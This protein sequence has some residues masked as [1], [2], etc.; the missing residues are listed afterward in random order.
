MDQ[1]E[2]AVKA[3]AQKVEQI[4]VLVQECKK[5]SVEFGIPFTLRDIE[6]YTDDEL[7]DEAYERGWSTSS[8]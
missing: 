8:C 5:L 3:M 1:K 7:Y 2:E 4:G 6:L